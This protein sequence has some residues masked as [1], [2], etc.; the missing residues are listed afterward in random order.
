MVEAL[1]MT[2]PAGSRYMSRVA[3]CGGLVRGSRGS[4]CGRD[5]GGRIVACVDAEEHEATAAEVASLRVSDGEGEGGGD[6]GV[7]GV[8]ALDWRMA[9]PASVASCWMVT[10]M[11]CWALDGEVGG[12]VVGRSLGVQ[13]AQ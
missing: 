9:R 11:A 1:G 13:E 3:A 2:L 6:G 10:T 12:I 5:R 7:D 8:A 4:G